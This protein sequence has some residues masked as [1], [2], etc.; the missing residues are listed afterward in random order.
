M[1]CSG[2]PS[3]N[4]RSRNNSIHALGS[5][6]FTVEYR[7]N[8]TGEHTRRSAARVY[9]VKLRYF[10]DVICGGFGPVRSYFSDG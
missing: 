8:D 6:L 5:F 2:P 3:V 1:W 9:S 7:P 10:R 4:T